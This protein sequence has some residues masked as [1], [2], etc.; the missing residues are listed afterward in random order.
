M[1]RYSLAELEELPTLSEGQFDN[2]KVET[3]TRRV[4]LSRC[5][6]ADGEPYPN[7]VTVERLI[8]GRWEVETTYQAK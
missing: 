1:K 6:V 8:N 4:W 5:G 3:S 7:K 2:L